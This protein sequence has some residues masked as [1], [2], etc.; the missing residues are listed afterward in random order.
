MQ[1]IVGP[2]M[3]PTNVGRMP[4]KRAERVRKEIEGDVARVVRGD[5]PGAG[6]GVLEEERRLLEAASPELSK[7]VSILEA[8]GEGEHLDQ[9]SE[10]AF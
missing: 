2:G 7:G 3:H 6:V 10:S 5:R 8:H 1:P 9:G 4:G